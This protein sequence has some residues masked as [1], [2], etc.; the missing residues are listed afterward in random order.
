MDPLGVFNPTAADT[1]TVSYT[2]GTC[3][4]YVVTLKVTD[5]CNNTDSALVEV[6]VSE[7]ADPVA[8][9]NDG[10]PSISITACSDC[11]YPIDF[12]AHGSDSNVSCPDLT[13]AWS[14]VVDSGPG[15]TP[16]FTPNNT[17]VETSCEFSDWG[18]YTV[19][20]VVTDL[21][22][23][24]DSDYVS[25]IVSDCCLT[26]SFTYA[27][28]SPDTGDVITFDASASSSN[29]GCGIIEYAWDWNYETSF[30]ADYTTTADTVDHVYDTSGTYEV[31]LRVTDSCGDSAITTRLVTV[32]P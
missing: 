8:K 23:N 15:T 7:P 21:C 32:G 5:A 30:S 29:C 13:Y 31:A 28:A 12:D 4:T 19:T 9:I 3:D 1:E 14:I 27:P 25:V 11:T 22:G 10:S 17:A 24:S 2:F 16:T 6:I 20:L 18:T 26:A